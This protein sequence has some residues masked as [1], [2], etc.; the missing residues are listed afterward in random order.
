[1]TRAQETLTL[2]DRGDIRNPYL[3]Q[4]DGEFLLRR[5]T[6]HAPLPDAA[7]LRRRYDCLGQKDLYLDYAGRH[8]DGH[9]VHQQLAKLG[10]GDALTARAGERRIGL[11]TFQGVCVAALADSAGQQW[12]DR[13]DRIEE[14][15][16][17]AMV[18]RSPED[19]GGEYRRLCQA[20]RW[21]VPL[22]EIMFHNGEK[23]VQGS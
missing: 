8:P 2:I 7:V 17:Q 15:R 3:R 20:S 12:R 4:L 9:A 1:M 13:L 14:I 23:S 6:S 19:S 5:E 10:P 11:Y 22:V 16:I 21:E 18:V